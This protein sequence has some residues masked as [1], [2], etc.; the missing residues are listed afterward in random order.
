MPAPT[1][2]IQQL[3]QHLHR[4]GLLKP[5]MCILVACSGGADSVA[6]LRLLHAVNQSQH[7]NWK[8][9][10]GHVNH[11]LR[12]R[13]SLRD[14]TFVRKLAQSLHLPLR[15]QRLNLPRKD[16]RRAVSEN[17]AREARY[18]ALLAMARRSRCDAI[19]LAHH[20]DDQ[21]ETILMR[22][23][24]GAGVTGLA[25]I[26]ESDLRGNIRLVRPLLPWPGEQLR[27]WL[28]AIGQNWR[29][30]SSNQNTQFFRNRIRHE[31]LPL[32]ETYQP[33]IR[34]LL[35]RNSRHDRAAADFLQ[36]HAMQVLRLAHY[37]RGK[38]MVSFAQETI[39]SAHPAPAALALRLA[40][41]D[42]GAQEDCINT[43]TLLDVLDK[44]QTRT[45]R[46][47]IQFA[48]AINLSV[49]KNRVMIRRAARVALK[50]RSRN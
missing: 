8:L 1:G 42:A 4:R 38:T 29:E 31:L 46:G 11:Q 44:L 40:L 21:A 37:R 43:P 50:K 49:H 26:H 25:G 12:G 23:L 7:W 32:L 6:L 20:A 2:L 14:E 33:R 19:V 30:D 16:Q 5:S 41:R 3:D 15:C 48:G 39:V 24:R 28:S 34:E 27:N 9:M 45:L 47:R 18:Q 22:L 17:I 10:V 36:Q 35:Q 13:E